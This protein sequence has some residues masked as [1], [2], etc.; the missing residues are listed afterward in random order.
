[1][2]RKQAKEDKKA[3]V[4]KHDLVEIPSFRNGYDDIFDSVMV[5]K[6]KNKAVLLKIPK[7][8]VPKSYRIQV[9]QGMKTRGISVNTDVNERGL[10]VW[11]RGSI[12][13]TE[14]KG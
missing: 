2:K 3:D 11:Y 9:I 4:A 12:I 14:D 6:E 5:A 8:S 13:V 10:Y 1:M 7:G